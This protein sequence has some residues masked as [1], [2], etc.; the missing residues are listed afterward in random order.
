MGLEVGVKLG[1]AVGLSVG[2]EVGVAVSVFVGEA[3]GVA[4]VVTVG[5][6]ET[7]AV[8]VDVKVL[9]GLVSWPPLAVPPLSCA[10]TV[11][12][13]T[14]FEVAAAVNVNVPLVEIAGCTLKGCCCCCSRRTPASACSHSV[15][16][17]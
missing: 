13:A 15:G 9:V 2:V 11:T 17:H 1:V 16:P 5:V 7:V 12:V 3:V 14:P 6:A 8:G 4:V 10:Y